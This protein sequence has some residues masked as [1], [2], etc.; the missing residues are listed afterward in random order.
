MPDSPPGIYTV[1][2]GPNTEQ[3][4]KK[5]PD[6]PCRGFYFQQNLLRY[7]PVL[8]TFFTSASETTPP[9]FPQLFSI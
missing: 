8:R 3:A 1:S 7:F 9:L 5:N 6:T 4:S 2:L